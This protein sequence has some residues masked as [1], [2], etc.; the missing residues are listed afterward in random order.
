MDARRSLGTFIA[1]V[2]LATAA[3]VPARA[4]GAASGP[5][6]CKN[7][8]AGIYPCKG[9]DL[10]AHLPATE[11]GGGGVADVWGWVDPETKRE[12]AILGTARGVDFVDVTEPTKPVYL[13]QLAG[14]PPAGLW[15]EIEI[16]ND[17]AY[18][19]C[20]L[21]PCGLEIFDLTRLRGVETEQPAWAP[22]AVYQVGAMHSID[23]NPETNHIFLNGAAL[24]VGT[25]LIFDVGTHP[26][27]PVPVGAMADDGYTHD[28][29]C[30]TY[31]GPDKDRKD[32]EICFNFNT[33]TVTIYDVT[34]NPQQPEQIARVTYDTA[35]YVHSGALSEDHSYL[36]STDEADETD[37]GTRSTLY[38]WDVRKLSDP[39]LIGTWVAN[40][41]TID[42]N[43]YSRDGDALFHANY[44]NGFRIM[45]MSQVS[46]GK[47]KEVAYIDTMPTEDGPVFQGAW[48]AYPFLPS[49]NMLVGDMRVGLF[50]VRP[51]PAILKRLR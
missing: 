28:S 25:P 30:R 36:I 42:H 38:I 43:I 49:G 46:K 51:D 10:L 7:G 44:A 18:I 2:L 14:K 39:K 47:L 23:S 21:T 6:A 11:M 1:L 31:H 17:H 34:A 5:I 35:S 22:D 8:K 29:L 13:G 32:H 26:L 16:L 27:V 20:D 24:A 33:D 3:V 45:D 19:V 4:Q 48:A 41:G 9:I 40:S 50:I 15:Q 12:Y 37:H